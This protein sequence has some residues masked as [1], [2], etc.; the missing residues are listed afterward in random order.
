MF[1]IICIGRWH[2][3]NYLSVGSLGRAMTQVSII[4]CHTST[5]VHSKV[6]STRGGFT[7]MAVITSDSRVML[8]IKEVI[9]PDLESS[10]T[11]CGRGNKYHHQYKSESKIRR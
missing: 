11:T 6:A 2:L 8:F 3:Y 5:F 4:I 1:L 10:E 7:V 9:F